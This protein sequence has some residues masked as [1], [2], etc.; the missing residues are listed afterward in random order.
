MQILLVQ[1]Q[2]LNMYDICHALSVYVIYLLQA[3]SIKRAAQ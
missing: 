1:Y 2:L 3:Y